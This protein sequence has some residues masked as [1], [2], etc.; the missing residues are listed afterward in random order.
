[1]NLAIMKSRT[2]SNLIDTSS[3]LPQEKAL[4]L[5]M[6]KILNGYKEGVLNR[7]IAGEKPAEQPLADVAGSAPARKEDAKTP[8]VKV[9][10]VNDV[11][12][13]VGKELETYGPFFKEQV[14]SLPSDVASILVNK[15]RAR[16]VE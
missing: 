5:N 1:M 8:Q 3:L 6:V 10:F 15:G 11:P 12:K 16:K 2:N 9:E 4:F 7:I 13:F 14:V